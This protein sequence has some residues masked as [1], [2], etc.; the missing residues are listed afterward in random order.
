VSRTPWRWA[1]PWALLAA[2]A[3][4]GLQF[5]LRAAVQVRT[6][7]ERMTEWL[8]L[9]VPIDAF[10]RGIQ[11]L[12]PKA[13][14][15]ALYGSAAVMTAAL[16]GLGALALRRRWSPA[17]VLGL[18]AA[19]FLAAMAGLMPLT[20]GGFFGAALA[21]HP[22]LVNGVYASVAL[23]YGALLLLGGAAVATPGGGAP[24]SGARWPG[25]RAGRR[26]LGVAA[27]SGA[28]SALAGLV[29]WRQSRIA[30]GSAGSAL[31]LA[32]A[33]ADLLRTGHDAPAA[34]T[35]PVATV[36]PG[37]RDAPTELTPE[38]LATAIAPPEPPAE[39]PEAAP[40]PQPEET[41]QLARDQD[42]ALEAAARAR[43]ELA[44]ALTP[45]RAHYVVTKNAVAD[46]ELDAETWRLVLDGEVY[47]PVQ[48]DYGTLRQLPAVELYKT[49][50]CISNFTAM[51]ELA[52]FGCDLIST[53]LWKGAR[54]RDVLELAGGLK[55]GVVSLRVAGADE[56]SSAIPPALATDPDTLLVYELNGEPLPRQHGYPVRLLS[57]GRYGFKSCKWVVGVRA[58]RTEHVDWY[59]QR[60]WSRTGVV[61]T[62]SRIDVPANG[63][64]LAPGRQRIAGVAYAGDRGVGAVQFSPD[65]GRTWNPADFLEPAPGRDAW[66]RWAAAFDLAPGETKRLVCR[67][68]DRLG[69]VQTAEFRLPQP[70]GGSG[71]HRIEVSGGA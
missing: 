45:T 29:A 53:S 13:K 7:P 22:L 61:K 57:P 24:P 50:E 46:P 31:P 6:L 4:V 36:H 33:P 32:R 42:G 19:L 17:A 11:T 58:L 44:P 63:A 35:P 56:F 67:A 9:Y 49:L 68:V 51:C 40:L 34:P 54:L 65:G 16:L 23:A 25:A 38:V 70:N 52:A 3:A 47:R 66:V 71:W 2:G 12:G 62:M 5:W 15:Y 43:G 64:R 1:L 41:R 37:L 10:A 39:T 26:R 55:P 59:G 8:L 27:V 30:G 28:G 60:N 18:T 69:Q 14:V 21:Q 48:V 20:G